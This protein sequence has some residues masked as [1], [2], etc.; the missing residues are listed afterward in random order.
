M[1]VVK[2]EIQE[3]FRQ[4]RKEEMRELLI[5]AIKDGVSQE[6]I[7][8]LIKKGNFNQ[9]EVKEIYQEAKDK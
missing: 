1:D 5:E 9:V 6:F 4:W 8:H 2:E 3:T 7:E